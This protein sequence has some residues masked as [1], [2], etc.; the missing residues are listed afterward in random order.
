MLLSFLMMQMIHEVQDFWLKKMM[1]KMMHK[2]PPKYHIS[3]VV[4]RGANQ[5]WNSPDPPRDRCRSSSTGNLRRDLCA[6]T[7]QNRQRVRPPVRPAATPRV[8][9]ARP[10]LET[11]PRPLRSNQRPTTGSTRVVEAARVSRTN[12]AATSGAADGRWIRC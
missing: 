2:S 6:L 8:P 1:Q 12:R 7:R 10:Q 5:P 9:R 3:C 4:T 11:T